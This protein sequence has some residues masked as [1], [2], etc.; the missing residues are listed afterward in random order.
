MVY[1]RPAR[2]TSRRRRQE[3]VRGARAWLMGHASL[4]AAYEAAA[5]RPSEIAPH[6]PRL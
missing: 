1:I 3:D 2:E 6:R 4:Y 5:P